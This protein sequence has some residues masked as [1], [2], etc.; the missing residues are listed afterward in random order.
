M[1]T[2]NHHKMQNFAKA[3]ATGKIMFAVHY[4]NWY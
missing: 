1:K 4:T 2:E 3:P